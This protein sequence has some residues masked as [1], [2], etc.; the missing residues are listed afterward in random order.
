MILVVFT[1]V[2]SNEIYLGI[3]ERTELG[4]LIGADNELG[5]LI[6]VY[7]FLSLELKYGYNLTIQ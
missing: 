1:L 7:N 2:T 6:G 5:Y 3:H 4:S